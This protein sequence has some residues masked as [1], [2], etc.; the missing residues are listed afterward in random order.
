MDAR[1]GEPVAL[2]RTEGAYGRPRWSPDGLRIA[3]FDGSAGNGDIFTVN[4]DGSGLTN[5]TRHPAFD[6]DPG[7]SPDGSRIAFVSDRASSAGNYA[8][9]VFVVDKNGESTSR[10]T[11]MNGWSG[12]PVWSPDGR[13]VVFSQLSARSAS[14]GLH[15]VSADGSFVVRLTTSPEGAWDASP[16]WKRA[17]EGSIGA[18]LNTGPVDASLDGLAESAGIAATI[19]FGQLDVGSPFPPSALP[20]ESAHAKDN[21]VPRTVVIDVGGTVTFEVPAG[22]HQIA[23]YAPGTEPAEI[24]TSALRALCPGPAARL[25]DDP[26]NRVAL[27]TSAC[28]VAWQAQY[29]FNTPGRY[30]VICAFLPHF[31][32][33]MYGWVEVRDRE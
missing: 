2:T 12:G 3:F 20:D 31:Q 7:W 8:R 15:V 10:L 16:T 32:V 11:F 25:I 27:I 18:L 29:T 21:L 13:Y 33:G 28:G 23:I 30:L 9:D 6:A 14:G 5:V 24:N 22:A 17:G 26:T 1:G 19:Q 4:V